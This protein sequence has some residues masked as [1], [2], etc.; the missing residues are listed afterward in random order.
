MRMRNTDQVTI[1]NC[2]QN[3]IAGNL[4]N[5]AL[6]RGC[7][8]ILRKDETCEFRAI[9]QVVKSNRTLGNKV[10]FPGDLAQIHDPCLFW[11]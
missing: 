11:N 1:L 7:K 6:Q 8:E 2:L 10:K 5:K 9:F 4:V 3:L